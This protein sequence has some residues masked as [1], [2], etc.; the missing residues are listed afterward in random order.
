[1]LAGGDGALAPPLAARSSWRRSSPPSRSSSSRRFRGFHGDPERHALYLLTLPVAAVLLCVYVAITVVEPPPAQR[2]A[3]RAPPEGAWSLRR[4]LA[5]L[6]AAAAATAVV[7][8]LLVDS[9]QSFGRSLGLSQFFVAAVIVALVG[10]AAEQGGAIVSRAAATRAS[11]PRS[12]SPRRRRSPSS[13]AR[14]SRCSRRLVGRGLPLSFRPV[15]LATMG[16]A[17]VVALAVVVA[18]ARRRPGSCRYRAV[19]LARRR[20]ERYPGAALRAR[21]GR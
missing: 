2:T 21:A 3:P 8:E 13:S 15:E 5:T 10:N 1:M 16:A 4:A 6:A 9:L 7:S 20:A 19:P 12:R 18:A 11:A 17:A 14:R